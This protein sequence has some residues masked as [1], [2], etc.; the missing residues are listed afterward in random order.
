MRSVWSDT[1]MG[2]NESG[3]QRR[4]TAEFVSRKTDFASSH[5]RMNVGL[6][7]LKRAL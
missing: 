6:L 3:V 4:K 2:K 5:Q 7:M 1:L